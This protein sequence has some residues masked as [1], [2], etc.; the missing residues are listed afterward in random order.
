M[1][2]RDPATS[3]RQAPLCSWIPP[4]LTRPLDSAVQWIA[5]GQWLYT[6]TSFLTKVE[7]D[8]RVHAWFLFPF[9]KWQNDEIKTIT[10]RSQ[11][12]QRREKWKKKLYNPSRLPRPKLLSRGQ[13]ANQNVWMR[14]V[15]ASH[16]EQSWHQSP[17][18]ISFFLFSLMAKMLRSKQFWAMDSK[19]LKL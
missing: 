17:C 7:V 9:C 15:W 6:S 8:N 19:A 18:L 5:R 13:G 10:S 4:A 3:C 1:T 2:S 11:N 16:L 14:I 12:L